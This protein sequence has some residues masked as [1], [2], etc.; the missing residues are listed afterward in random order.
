MDVEDAAAGED[1]VE[2]VAL[3][4]VVAGA[5]ADDHGL[6]VE[7][8]ERV[9]DAVEQHAVVGDDLLGLVVLARAAL[10]IAAAQV[11]R[12]QHAS[13][14]RRARASPAS[15]G[16]PARTGAPSRSRG[17]R[18]PP[19]CRR[20]SPSRVADD[21][22]VVAC[23]RCRAARARSLRQAARHLLVD[24]VDHLLLAAARL[25]TRRRRRRGLLA[26]AGRA[27]G[28]WPRRCALKPTSTITARISLIVSGLVALR[29]NIAAALPGLKLF[30][31]ILRSRLRMV[32]DTSPKSMS[33]GH[34]V[35][36]LVADGAVVGDVAR[37][38]P[39]A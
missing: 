1:L 24:E 33:T 27:A 14:R 9:G 10:R 22:H 37:T 20:W 30:W 38:R 32:I 36:A 18:T 16:R 34:G 6:D 23:P 35:Q 19:R 8:V 13:A 39:S 5:A 29:N 28:C 3:Q 17:N 2:L 15:R 7:V 26:G 25:P 31:P 11:A 21:R 12:R 4:L